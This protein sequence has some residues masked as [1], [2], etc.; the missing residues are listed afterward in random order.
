M[1]EHGVLPKNVVLDEGIASVY[2]L[3]PVSPLPGDY[4]PAS[5]MLALVLVLAIAV[6]VIQQK[7]LH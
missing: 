1:S 7:L 6:I 2:L 4:R 5:L 3:R